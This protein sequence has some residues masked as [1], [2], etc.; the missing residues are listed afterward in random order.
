[1]KLEK[2]KSLLQK[3]RWRIRKKIAGTSSIPRLCLHL[4][5]QHVYAQCIDDEAGKTL[6]SI[7][8]LHKDVRGQQLKPNLQGAAALG[9]L[10]A[11]SAKQVKIEK[12][13][14]DRNGRRFHGCVKAF[15]EAVR[16]EGLIF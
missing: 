11:H 2:K 12:V 6:V 10:L 5:N 16:E 15:A 8:S 9:K 13:V 7:S 1:M 14:F 4:S 3:R